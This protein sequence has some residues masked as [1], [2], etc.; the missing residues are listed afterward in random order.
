MCFLGEG[1]IILL[2]FVQERIIVCNEA[3]ALKT[4]WEDKS[5]LFKKILSSL[6][7]TPFFLKYIYENL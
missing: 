1:G 4:E 5:C 6:S 2:L 3:A 7:P